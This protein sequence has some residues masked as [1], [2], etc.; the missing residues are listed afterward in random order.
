MFLDH[1]GAK[2]GGLAVRTVFD[3]RRQLDHGY[4]STAMRRYTGVAIDSIRESM[5]YH[6]W[7]C[8][9]RQGGSSG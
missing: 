1:T 3:G 4:T 7:L 6:V 8:D 2:E 9:R 5:R